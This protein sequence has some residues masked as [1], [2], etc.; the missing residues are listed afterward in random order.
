MRKFEY[1]CKEPENIEN[2]KAAEADDFKG[3]DCH[4]RLETHNSDGERRLVDITGDELIALGM[5][6]NRPASELIFLTRAEHMALHRK[7]K[8]LSE[9]WKRKISEVQKGKHLS[10]E[11]R[12]KISEV[13]KGKHL[14]E[15]TKRKISESLKG[16][17]KGRHWKLVDGKRVW[18]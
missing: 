4:H 13:Q 1:Y 17:L 18:N 6:Y 12:K 2:Y 10:E 15:E 11:H 7:G 14:F 3:W 8:C 5:Y 16:K 9:E